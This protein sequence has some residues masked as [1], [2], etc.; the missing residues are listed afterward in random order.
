MHAPKQSK[1]VCIKP[2]R[3]KIFTLKPITA[4]QA[5]TALYLP[6]RKY[7]RYQAHL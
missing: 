5:V 2:G 7:S 3:R 4:A 1:G 6:V